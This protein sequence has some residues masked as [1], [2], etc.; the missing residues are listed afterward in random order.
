MLERAV[1]RGTLM[2]GVRSYARAAPPGAPTPAEPDN[3]D[4]ALAQALAT[5][6]GLR[7]H[8]AGLAPSDQDAALREGR[9]DLVIAGAADA[10]RPGIG[11]A[12]T[13]G[14]YDDAPGM[15]VTLR[16]GRLSGA[17]DL[18]GAS[19][20][21][22]QGSGYASTLVRRHG[23]QPKTFPSSV[24]CRIGVHGGRVP[25]PGRPWRRPRAAAAQRRV[26]LLSRLRPRP[27]PSAALRPDVRVT[28]SPHATRRFVGSKSASPGCRPHAGVG[29]ELGTAPA[30]RAR[31][32]G[33]DL[34]LRQ[35]D[36]RSGGPACVRA[37]ARPVLEHSS[38]TLACAH[39]GSRPVLRRMECCE[40]VLGN[41]DPLRASSHPG[42][43]HARVDRTRRLATAGR[44]AVSSHVGGRGAV[45][46]RGAAPRH[47][48]ARRLSRRSGRLHARTGRGLRLGRGH[49]GAQ[50]RRHTSAAASGYRMATADSGRPHRA[51]RDVVRPGDPGSCRPGPRCS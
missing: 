3:Y 26:A 36:P 9:A 18:A 51:G 13:E 7:L 33:V 39:R 41:P 46:A 47:S 49:S 42:I 35:H 27:R 15:L 31:G 20:C 5:R 19:V 25:S 21:V 16:A 30:R 43:H 40:H 10:P 8:L 32:F 4:V 14:G 45:G 1:Q 2:V 37:A 22:P 34:S 6:L 23:A 28:E 50:A 44:Q 38:G 29:N 17:A 11:I 12:A 24:P 48:S